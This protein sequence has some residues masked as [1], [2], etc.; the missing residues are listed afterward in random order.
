[1][2]TIEIFFHDLNDDAKKRYIEIF[3][4]EDENTFFEIRV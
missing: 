2:K 3:D 4:C 1:M